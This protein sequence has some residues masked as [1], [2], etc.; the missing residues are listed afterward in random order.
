[1]KNHATFPVRIAIL[2][3]LYYGPMYATGVANWIEK[4]TGAHVIVDSKTVS[5]FF[6]KLE[7][8]GLIEFAKKSSTTGTTRG[9]KRKY[10]NITDQGRAFIINTREML[11]AIFSD[12][13]DTAKETFNLEDTGEEEH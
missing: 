3:S 4:V 12:I 11:K 9:V 2:Q 1:M 13:P 5:F 10:Y 6:T 8:E 7:K